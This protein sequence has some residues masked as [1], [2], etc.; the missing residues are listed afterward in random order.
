MPCEPFRTGDG[1]AVIV[2]SRGARAST[3]A[4]FVQGCLHWAAVQCDWPTGLGKT[5]D[6][7]CC[8]RH[9]RR[10]GPDKDHCLEHFYAGQKAGG[11]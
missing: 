6:R 7:F 1:G 2:C 9:S 5:C 3:V 4:C 11:A 8:D 10:V